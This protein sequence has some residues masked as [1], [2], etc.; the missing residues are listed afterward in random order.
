MCACMCVRTYVSVFLCDCICVHVNVCV[1]RRHEPQS[2]PQ[3]SSSRAQRSPSPQILSLPVTDAYQSVSA[4]HPFCRG[5]DPVLNFCLQT[6]KSWREQQSQQTGG[7]LPKGVGRASTWNSRC[8]H[9]IRK[10]A[11]L[12]EYNLIFLLHFGRKLCILN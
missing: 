8:S 6:C 9:F 3:H 7:W 11:A 2:S 10:L 1:C 5:S 12:E 4:A